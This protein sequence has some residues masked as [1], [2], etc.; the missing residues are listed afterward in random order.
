[1]DII[2]ILGGGISG[3]TAAIN[4]H[5]AGF[6]V[7]V[8]ERKDH[9]GKD[10]N[11]F[12]FLENWIFQEDVVDFLHSVEI[13]TDFYLKPWF[14]LEVLSPSLRE[15]VG[16]SARPFM[17]LVKR[18]QSEDSID[19]CLEN[20][21]LNN[22]IR[23]IYKSELKDHEANIIATG[24]KKPDWVAIGI[25]FSCDYPDKAVILLSNDLSFRIYS[26]LIVSDNIGEIACVNPV[27]TKDVEARLALAVD[28][29]RQKYRIGIS[30]INERLS[31]TVSV[32]FLN[33]AR[34]NDQYLVGEAAGFQDCL[35]GFGMTYAFKSGYYVA[36][37]IIGSLDYD[38]LWKRDFLK[39]L[40]VSARNRALYERLSDESFEKLVDL[41]NNESPM[42]TRL[43]GGR[44]FH[45]ILKKLYHN[46]VP[47]PLRYFIFR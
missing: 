28:I 44:D 1:M 4:L 11:D 10:T 27:G 38:R 12:Q 24:P 29:L 32:H 3:L 31:G 25:K 6:N 47:L 37:S 17:Y 18:G 8:H 20:Q 13:E 46:S 7:E 14:S 5:K 23:I 40:R 19:K 30:E 34:I 33:R 26:Y 39:Q 42:V 15:Y 43:I 16:R 35:A 36:K 41:L 9:C 21:A 45:N 2:R 22:G